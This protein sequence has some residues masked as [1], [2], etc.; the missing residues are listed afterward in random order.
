MPPLPRSS[1]RGATTEWTVIAPAISTPWG[2]KAELALFTHVNGYPSA[3][4]PV[5]TSESS[6]I[7]IN[8]NEF[9]Q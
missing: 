2:W 3:A 7:T 6:I 5:Q 9:H 1:P 8:V 4:G